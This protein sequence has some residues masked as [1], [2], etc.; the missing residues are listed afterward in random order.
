MPGATFPVAD[1]A[2][3][4]VPSEKLSLATVLS[5]ELSLMPREE[6]RLILVLQEQ[7]VPKEDFLTVVQRLQAR[8][9]DEAPRSEY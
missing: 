4:T 7:G 6:G 3:S 5:R 2:P 9:G 8:S 1:K